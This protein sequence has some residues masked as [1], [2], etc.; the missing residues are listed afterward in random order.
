MSNG[1]CVSTIQA[2]SSIR[3]VTFSYSGSLIGYTTDKMMGQES[4]LRITDIRE[5]N[6]SEGK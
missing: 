5:K 3:G 1:S 4:E 6:D 2:K